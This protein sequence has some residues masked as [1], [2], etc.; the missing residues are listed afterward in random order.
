MLFVLAL[1]GRVSAVMV[2]N[3]NDG[4]AF[5]LDSVDWE[6]TYL[7]CPRAYNCLQFNIRKVV[8]RVGFPTKLC[9]ERTRV[10]KGH[11]NQKL[12]SI[13]SRPPKV[14]FS[15]FLN[16]TWLEKVRRKREFISG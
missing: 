13:V 11:N 9:L 3:Q 7:L 8:A 2:E 10:R 16:L 6:T 5:S 15:W 12:F 1:E 14:R 4:A